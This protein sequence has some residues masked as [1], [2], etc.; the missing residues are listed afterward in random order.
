MNQ[1]Y[2]ITGA[3]GTGKTEIAKII[4][5]MYSKIGVLPNNKFVKVT[6]QD[7]IA[8]YLGQ[9]AIKTSKVIKILGLEFFVEVSRSLIRTFSLIISKYF[10]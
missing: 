7:L 10:L 8:G 3:P 1:K 4:G 9:T 6:R 2:I 5:R